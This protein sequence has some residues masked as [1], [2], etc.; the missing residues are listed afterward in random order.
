MDPSLS[1]GDA[2]ALGDKLLAPHSYTAVELLHQGASKA[3]VRA[4]RNLDRRSV[5]FKFLLRNTPQGLEGLRR[6]VSFLKQ[7]HGTGV[8]SSKRFLTHTMNRNMSICD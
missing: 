3:V 2:L 5:I 8:S 6:E 1:R 7:L 4:K